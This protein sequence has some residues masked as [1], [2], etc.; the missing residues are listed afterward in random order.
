MSRFGPDLNIH[1]LATQGAERQVG[2]EDAIHPHLVRTRIDVDSV[3][4][5]LDLQH[6]RRLVP[7]YRDPVHFIQESLGWGHSARG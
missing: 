2:R 3:F 1:Q 4:R 5:A 7:C 6:E